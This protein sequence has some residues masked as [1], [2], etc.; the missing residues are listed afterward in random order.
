MGRYVS[1]NEKGEKMKTKRKIFFFFKKGLST[2]F[3]LFLNCV[4]GKN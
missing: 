1:R 4:K 3:I 2:D